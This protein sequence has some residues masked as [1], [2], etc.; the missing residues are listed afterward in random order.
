MYTVH[1]YCTVYILTTQYLLLNVNNKYVDRVLF[2]TKM[3]VDLLRK[4]CSSLHSSSKD[5]ICTSNN[6]QNKLTGPVS[7]VL[8]KETLSKE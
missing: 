2:V 3:H 7:I 6:S 8:I 5:Y 1:V 4:T